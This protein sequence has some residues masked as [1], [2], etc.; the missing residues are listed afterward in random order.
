MARTNGWCKRRPN[1]PHNVTKSRRTV[2]P[3]A[4]PPRAAPNCSAAWQPHFAPSDA[5][6]VAAATTPRGVP[7]GGRLLQLRVSTLGAPHGKC[8]ESNFQLVRSVPGL[9]ICMT[10]D[11][12]TRPVGWRFFETHGGKLTAAVHTIYC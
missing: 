12:S 8:R 1:C 2:G 7:R 11:L 4:E 6:S 5:R 3:A 9:G 10:A